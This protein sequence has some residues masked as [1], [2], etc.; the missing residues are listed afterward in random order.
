MANAECTCENGCCSFNEGGT[1]G[2][3]SEEDI[4]ADNK[5]HWRESDIN[6]NDPEQQV[7][8]PQVHA[9][10]PPGSFGNQR[11]VDEETSKNRRV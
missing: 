8:P 10:A 7:I 4:G 3:E 2:R 1:K 11:K 6:S 5:R 9:R